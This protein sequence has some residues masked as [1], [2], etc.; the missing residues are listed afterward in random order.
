MPEITTQDIKLFKSEVMADTPDGG[1]AMTG[2][3]VVDGELNNV[4]TDTSE[5]DR[6][7]GRCSIRF[8]Y[9]AVVT[10]DRETLLGTHC[11]LTDPPD[12][13]RVVCT[14]LGTTGSNLRREDAREYIEQFLSAGSPTAM[15]LYDLHPAGSRT[16]V[17]Y[18]PMESS[19]PQ[20]SDVIVLSIEKAGHV[21]NGYQQ[22]VRITGLADEAFIVDPGSSAQVTKRLLTIEISEPLEIDF[23]GGEIVRSPD[24]EDRPTR[25][26]STNPN[27]S[28]RYYGVVPLAADVEE[29]DTTLQVETIL[30]SVVPSSYAESPILDQQ[31][32]SE[33]QA[34][35]PAGPS[36]TESITASTDA[37]GNVF[38][39]IP[40]AARPG[41]VEVV[42]EATGTVNDATFEDAGAGVLERTAG[43]V[44]TPNAAGTV[45]YATRELVFA[46][47]TPS[48]SYTF[49][50]TYVPAAAVPDV[51]HTA[52]TLI[53]LANKGFNYNRTL[54]PKPSPGTVAVSY[55]ALGKWYTLLDNGAG[56]LK[57]ATGTGTGTINYVTGTVNVTCGYQTDVDSHVLFGWGSGAHYL[58]Q[59]AHAGLQLGAIRL[60][61][62]EACKPGTLSITWSH[63]ST[64][65]EVT[66]DGAG[67]LTGDCVSGAIDYSGQVLQFVPTVIPAKLSVI[68][69]NYNKLGV[70]SYVPSPQPTPSSG[71]VTITIPG[72]PHEPG[73]I[74][75]R[76]T[77]RRAA[78]GEDRQVELYDDG[79]GNLRERGTT[80]GS[81]NYTT[82]VASFPQTKNY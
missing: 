36:Y 20:V 69:C 19:M 4:F 66:D 14:I 79:A 23:P 22:F 5:L 48:I 64:D 60:A 21:K 82:G 44:N 71:T 38:F 76:L 61:L 73:S 45:N 27:A 54:I 70:S 24:A 26:R 28:V 43:G 30:Q 58:D 68:T 35:V 34:I 57:G 51:Q 47:L 1:G 15:S 41:S 33:T 8:I 6:I 9:G 81:V 13:S 67:N 62:E 78:T 32:G 39:S 59:H 31:L 74:L 50:V 77:R 75:I 7:R 18:Q 2:Q 42:A 40:R 11:Y 55:S 72:A 49:S 80:V 65:Y 3:E 12:D 56:Q 25:I 10:D 53:T 63:A 46:G 17:A 52:G 16:L 37:G 29:G